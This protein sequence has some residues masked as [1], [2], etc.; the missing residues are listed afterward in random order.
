MIKRLGMT[1]SI[2]VPLDRQD[3]ILT[4]ADRCG[5]VVSAVPALLVSDWSCS[6]TNPVSSDIVPTTVAQNIL[7]ALPISPANVSTLQPPLLLPLK[8]PVPN[9]NKLCATDAD[10]E[11]AYE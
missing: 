2:S 7:R 3:V 8:R 11:Y 5:V 10:V 9:S 4:P 1:G 6:Y